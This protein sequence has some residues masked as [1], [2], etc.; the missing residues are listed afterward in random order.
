MVD[1]SDD[2]KPIGSL[3][4]FDSLTGIEATVI[5]EEKLKVSLDAENIFVSEKGDRALRLNDIV[6]SIITVVVGGAE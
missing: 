1:L 6:A 4:G 2:S 3:D 5:L